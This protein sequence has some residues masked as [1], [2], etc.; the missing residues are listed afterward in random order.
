MPQVGESV[1]Q[2][3]AGGEAAVLECSLCLKIF[4]EP[5]T[6]ACG[7]TFCRECLARSVDHAAH[8]PLCRTT[9]HMDPDTHPVTTA[10]QTACE[11]LFPK[12]Y[13]ERQVEVA[14]EREHALPELDEAS[15]AAEE[16]TV[17]QPASP[18]SACRSRRRRRRRVLRLPLF[19]LDAVVFPGQ[20][21][22]MHVFEPRYRLMLRRVM[23]GSRQFGLL[24][25]LRRSASD[26]TDDAGNAA[27]L[28]RHGQRR[29]LAPVGTILHVTRSERLG[30]GRSLI[31]TVGG[32]RFRVA[33]EDT[34]NVDGYLVGSVELIDGGVD[35]AEADEDAKY[36]DGKGDDAQRQALV[37]AVLQEA[38]RV[39]DQILRFGLGR[40]ASAGIRVVGGSISEALEQFET[41]QIITRPAA[42]ETRSSPTRADAAQT[43]A[44]VE[45][46][47]AARHTAPIRY[48]YT[49]AS[50]KKLSFWL[51]A[52]T[53]PNSDTRQ[54]L[55]EMSSSV[56]RIEAVL[57]SVRDRR[58]DQRCSIA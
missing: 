13:E 2:V 17:D 12:L 8:C 28:D 52:L 35:A 36:V 1:A 11:R 37:D 55:L 6:T 5:V 34:F 26:D 15:A 27:R 3:D 39:A 4:Y 54:R 21:F 48:E 47:G 33:P 56:A 23:A 16:D 46:T 42:A 45:A 40:S 24:P 32:E 44:A 29:A 58:L 53:T 50:V 25:L 20:R 9:L 38:F 18:A 7:H 22:P 41:P 10:V 57:Q 49:Y 19:V 43:A 30:D 31:D 14:R 51:A